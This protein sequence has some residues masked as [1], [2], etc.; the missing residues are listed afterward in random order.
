MTRPGRSA[1]SQESSSSPLS[2]EGTKVARIVRASSHGWV[3]SRRGSLPR[4][5]SLASVVEVLEDDEPML[6]LRSRGSKV[7]R[8]VHSRRPAITGLQGRVVHPYL[9]PLNLAARECC[10]PGNM[11]CAPCP[12]TKRLGAGAWTPHRERRRAGRPKFR[13]I[14]LPTLLSTPLVHSSDRLARQSSRSHPHGPWDPSRLVNSSPGGPPSRAT[15]AKSQDSRDRVVPARLGDLET[16]DQAHRRDLEPLKHRSG[17][18]APRRTSRLKT[19]SADPTR[20][21]INASYQ[22]ILLLFPLRVGECG[23]GESPCTIRYGCHT[24]F[25]RCRLTTRKRADRLARGL[26]IK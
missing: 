9:R 26:I 3:M 18:G 12:R 14:I 22:R 2:Q 15:K 16:G 8:V 19:G 11:V 20:H 6:S 24:T 17:S 4:T 13:S 1:S 23:L 25:C 5:C 10:T 7:S 21:R